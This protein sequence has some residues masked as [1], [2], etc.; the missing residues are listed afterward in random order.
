MRVSALDWLAVFAAIFIL[1]VAVSGWMMWFWRRS[2][3]LHETQIHEMVREMREVIDEH[4]R[5]PN[6]GD[7]GTKE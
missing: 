6:N 7:D 2:L 5:P 3:R 1:M 4:A